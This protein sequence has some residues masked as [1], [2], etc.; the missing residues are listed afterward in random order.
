MESSEDF[1]IIKT[2]FFVVQTHRQPCSPAAAGPAPHLPWALPGDNDKAHPGVPLTSLW[3][4][5]AASTINLFASIP[6]YMWSTLSPN[7][8]LGY[9]V[10]FFEAKNEI[11]LHHWLL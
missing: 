4:L 8:F 5:A 10:A 3:I 2:F 1:F 7:T 6:P 11:F 9:G